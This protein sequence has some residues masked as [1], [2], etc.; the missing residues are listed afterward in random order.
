MRQFYQNGK[1]ISKCIGFEMISDDRS[2]V[3]I[4]EIPGWYF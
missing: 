2:R 3:E 4:W 1:I